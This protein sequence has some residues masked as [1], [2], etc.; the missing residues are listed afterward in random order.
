MQRLL[1]RDGVPVHV[2]AAQ[3]DGRVVRFAARAEDESAA[4]WGI[5]RLRFSLGVDLDLREFHDRYRSDPLI[6]R[7]VR[8]VPEHRPRLRPLAWEALAWAVCEQLIE[9]GEA[10]AICRA[11]VRKAGRRCPETGLSDVPTPEAIAAL[12]PAEIAALEL[13]PSRA[14]SLR[15]AAREVA[16]G[17]VD[18][19]A[20][21]RDAQEAGWRRLLA[22][23]GIGPWTVEMT[24]Y[25]GQG[26]FDQVPAG[27]LGYL[28]IVGRLLTGNP[29]ARASED[30]VRELLAPYGEWKGLAAEYLRIA[31]SRGLLPEPRP[32]PGGSARRLSPCG[33]A[34]TARSPRPTRGR[35]S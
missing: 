25:Y 24:A 21:D 1:H 5:E 19:Q 8:S 13:A 16:R 18:L 22:L 31:T 6:G 17:R 34:A 28:K 10:A 20:T 9:F 33:S 15:A 3:I 26:R 29:Q 2:G 35:A 23:R 32:R 4:A 12:A 11:L 27:D 14:L 30:E 7:A